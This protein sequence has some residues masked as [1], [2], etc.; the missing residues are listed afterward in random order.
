MYIVGM[1]RY[2]VVS[3]HQIDLGE[4]GTTEKLVGVVMNMT[5]WIAVRDDPGVECPVIGTGAPTV[6]LLGHDV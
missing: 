4:G 1:D 2:L 6:V 5:D 3:S